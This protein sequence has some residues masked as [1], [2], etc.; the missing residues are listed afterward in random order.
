MDR[1]GI[2]NISSLTAFVM[3][4]CAE[5]GTCNSLDEIM[6]LLF[7]FPIPF[8]FVVRSSCA[9]MM[10]II[11]VFL[12]REGG[13]SIVAWPLWLSYFSSKL[14]ISNKSEIK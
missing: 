3:N 6:I 5:A 13:H 12:N 2:N 1:E 14:Q 7:F 8:L 4:A 9:V 10:R 11:C